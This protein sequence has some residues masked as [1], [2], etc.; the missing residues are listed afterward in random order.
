MDPY[1]TLLEWSF[2][3][4]VA[5]ILTI[6]GWLGTALMRAINK[7]NEEAD[8]NRESIA[9][10]RLYVAENYARKE[11]IKGIYAVLRDIQQDIKMLLGKKV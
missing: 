7:A 4:A 11:D 6:G 2:K 8:M 10:H 9:A 1:N 3:G 5:I